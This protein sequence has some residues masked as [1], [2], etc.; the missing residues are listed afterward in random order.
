MPP[1]PIISKQDLSLIHI[2]NLTIATLAA[3]FQLNAVQMSK[4]YKEKTGKKILTH[5][6][7]IRCEQAKKLLADT[8]MGG[9]QIAESVG[10]GSLRTFLRVFKQ[11]TGVTPSGYREE[12]QS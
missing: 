4:I 10:F 6:A 1:K 2:C 12:N 5:L 11:I 3:H 7:E 8:S 9:A